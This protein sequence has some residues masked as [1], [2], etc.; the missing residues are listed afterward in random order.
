ML[1]RWESE[2]SGRYYLVHVQEDLFGE[3]T[4]R[5]V[6]GGGLH[7]RRGGERI[8]CLSADTLDRR[9]RAIDRVR[10]HRGYLPRALA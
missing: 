10:R 9:L 3:L 4:L 7:G 6:W 5:R 1:M 2:A 8:E